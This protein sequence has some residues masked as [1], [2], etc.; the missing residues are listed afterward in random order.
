MFQFLV[1]EPAIVL[2]YFNLLQEQTLKVVDK[3]RHLKISDFRI[4]LLRSLN[5]LWK[6]FWIKYKLLFFIVHSSCILITDLKLYLQT[7]ST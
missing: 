4:P 6:R 3:R 5:L 7:I 1:L 2:S